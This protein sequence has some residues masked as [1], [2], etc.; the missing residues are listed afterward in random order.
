MKR[1]AAPV[2]YIVHLNIEL[3]LSIC[4]MLLKDDFIDFCNFFRVWSL[5]KTRPEI[6]HLLENLDWT[7]MHTFDRDPLSATGIRFTRFL[8]SCKLWGVKHAFC[9]EACKNLILGIEPVSNLQ[10][11]N[12]IRLTHSLSFLAYYLFLPYYQHTPPSEC[13][14]ILFK[15]FSNNYLCRVNLKQNIMILTARRVAENA[16][17]GEVSPIVLKESICP[18]HGT[19]HE[20]HLD[21]QARALLIS[22][23][24]KLAC[25]HCFAHI[26]CCN[27]FPSHRY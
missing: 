27:I 21:Y 6:C 19:E 25:Y 4:S 20:G 2:E 10:L 23:V 22:D 17:L 26:I 3:I 14:A 13:V 18:I 16:G 9:Y 24:E 1:I 7:N 12:D 5:T 11:L 15:E 8:S